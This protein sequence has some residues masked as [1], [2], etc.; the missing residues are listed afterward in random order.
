MTKKAVFQANQRE[1]GQ[2]KT[3]GGGNAGC[4][5]RAGRQKNAV[6]RSAFRRVRAE[7]FKGLLRGQED[8]K[9]VEGPDERRVSRAI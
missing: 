3:G 6:R 5:F 9:E 1:P 8:H 2:L 4:G 7:G